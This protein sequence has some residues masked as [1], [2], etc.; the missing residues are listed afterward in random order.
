MVKLLIFCSKISRFSRFALLFSP[1]LCPCSLVLLC[2]YCWPLGEVRPPF[3]LLVGAP[4]SLLRLASLASIGA[5]PHLIS[6]GSVVRPIPPI[7]GF[8]PRF[9][10]AAMPK[11]GSQRVV[12]TEAPQGDARLQSRIGNDPEQDPE[13]RKHNYKEIYIHTQDGVEVY[14]HKGRYQINGG[15]FHYWA[16]YEYRLYVNDEL[17]NIIVDENMSNVPTQMPGSKATALTHDFCHLDSSGSDEVYRNFSFEEMEGRTVPFS[18]STCLKMNTISIGPGSVSQGSSYEACDV[19]LIAIAMD[20]V[21]STVYLNRAVFWA[22]LRLSLHV[23]SVSNPTSGS[24]VAGENRW[25]ILLMCWFHNGRISTG[26][27]LQVATSLELKI[28]MC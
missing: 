19:L 5:R 13:M 11:D 14:H 26:W 25:I 21:E 8:D 1:C 10:P 20:L 22:Y 6:S 24:K 15:V 9:K 2:P 27:L 12:L 4:V 17:W 7:L 28:I 18:L 16:F 23:K 3:W